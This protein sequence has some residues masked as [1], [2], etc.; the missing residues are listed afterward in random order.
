MVHV[1][2]SCKGNKVV[3]I[4]IVF[5][6][7]A[8]FV[9]SPHPDLISHGLKSLLSFIH[10]LES[11]PNGRQPS[12]K[13]KVSSRDP[14]LGLN[15]LVSLPAPLKLHPSPPLVGLGRYF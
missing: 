15:L 9:Q 6:P 5:H 3:L 7:T 4:R 14:M 10:T 2:F 13:S 1:I 8:L 12:R 11:H